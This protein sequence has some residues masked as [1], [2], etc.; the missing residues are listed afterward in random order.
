M[1]KKSIL[2]TAA[3]ITLLVSCKSNGEKEAATSEAKELAKA[4]IG[5]GIYSISQHQ[6]EMKWTAYKT[7]AAHSGHVS[8]IGGDL[9]LKDG[10]IESGAFT[11][12]IE[13]LVAEDGDMESNEKLGVHLKG[14]DFFDVAKYN[15]ATFQIT[16][17]NSMNS[18]SIM[19]AGNLTIKDSTI[20]IAFPTMMKMDGDTVMAAAKFAID[21][22]KWGLIYQPKDKMKLKDKFIKDNIDLDIRIR[23]VKK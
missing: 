2:I 1:I 3:A 4:S 10:Q 23:A 18:D 7:G 16:S 9:M 8:I 17:V 12:N 21:R 20:N 19:L 13:S 6:C 22:S 14:P 15:N 5:S 11:I